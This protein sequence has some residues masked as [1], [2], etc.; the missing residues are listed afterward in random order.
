MEWI[1]IQHPAT[2]GHARVAASA[3]PHYLRC[4]WQE[5]PPDPAPAPAPAAKPELEDSR[6][7]EPGIGSGSRAAGDSQAV[8][9]Q[10]GEPANKTSRRR[11][12]NNDKPG[13]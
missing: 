7:N 5:A 11:A 1:T 4:G 8:T 12:G 10:V 9:G 6:L 3:L 2:G 13:E